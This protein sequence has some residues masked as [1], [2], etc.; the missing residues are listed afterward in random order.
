LNRSDVFA[1]FGKVLKR[2]IAYEYGSRNELERRERNRHNV[3]AY[4]N[5]EPILKGIR[6]KRRA[7]WALVGIV[8]AAGLF[9]A[10]R[11]G[12]GIFVSWYADNYIA[13]PTRVPSSERPDGVCLTWNGDPR[14][15]QA[16]QWRTA[17]SVPDGWIEYREGDNGEVVQK[18]ALAATIEDPMVKN[19]PVNHRFSV[20]LSGLT[21]GKAYNYR[22][23]S[24]QKNVWSDWA[25]F[26][27]APDGPAPFSFVYLGDVQIGFDYWK[28]LLASASKRCPDAAFYVVAGDLVNKGPYRDQWDAFFGAMQGILDRRPLVPTLGNHDYGKQEVPQRYLDM[29]TLPENGPKGVPAEHAY[30]FR[31]GNAFFV[32]LDSNLDPEGQAPWLEEQLKGSDAKWKIAIYHHPAYSSSPN[33]DNPEVREIWGQI[34][35]KYHVDMALQGHDHAYLRTYPMKAEKR[36]DPGDGTYYAVTVSGQKYYD[37]KGGEAAEVLFPKTSTYQILRVSTNPDVLTYRAYDYDGKERD[38]LTLTK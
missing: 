5:P 19:D 29:F 20:A 24:K 36:V 8:A 35:D 12:K 21:P 16:V 17:P 10:Y 14:S 13:R 11:E 27:T 4:S 26:T 1:G 31:Y 30:S 32:V 2:T 3:A 15:T 9:F 25:S 6:M 33:R 38:S 22:V 28:N 37:Q 18:E 7:V 23:G 34:F